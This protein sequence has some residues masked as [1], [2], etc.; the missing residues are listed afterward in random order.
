MDAAVRPAFASNPRPAIR[1]AGAVMPLPPPPAL[2]SEEHF[3]LNPAADE[4]LPAVACADGKCGRGGKGGSCDCFA[5]AKA[6]ATVLL[7]L[8]T[9][10]RSATDLQ[11]MNA[12]AEYF[13]VYREDWLENAPTLNPTGVR[14]LSG[15]VR[16]LGMVPAPI[17]VE[18]SGIADLD[19]RRRLAITGWLLEAG[20]STAEAAGRVVIG[21][22]R[23]EGLRY[24]DI[25]RVYGREVSGGGGGGGG[26]GGFGGG[27]GFGGGTFGGGG[28][29]GGGFGGGGFGGG[30]FG[31]FR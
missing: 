19:D 26:G 30:G 27:N 10:V 11:R 23:A 21:G 5:C 1:T 2:A 16:R 13:V 12:L 9:A 15:I 25:E 18:P 31:G 6:P 17:R 8:G 28:F 3:S 4:G 20:V 24:T 14:H 29:G 22:T 7:P